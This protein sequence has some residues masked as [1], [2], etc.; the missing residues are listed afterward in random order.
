MNHSDLPW[1]LSIHKD[2]PWEIC[3]GSVSSGT[4]KDRIICDCWPPDSMLTQSE[5]EANAEFI[6]MVC[7]NFSKNVPTAQEQK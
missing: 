1:K 5:A 6:L 4:E 3:G 7:N 2:S